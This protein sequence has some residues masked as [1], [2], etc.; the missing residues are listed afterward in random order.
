MNE[1]GNNN[2]DSF[3]N[4]CFEGT[5]F[6]DVL[7]EARTRVAIFGWVEPYPLLI[8][9]LVLLMILPSVF[10]H[11][12][13]LAKIARIYNATRLGIMSIFHQI[14]YG[15]SIAKSLNI[16]VLQATPCVHAFVF[17]GRIAL[18]QFPSAL[19]LSGALFAFTVMRFVGFT[20]LL[21]KLLITV[22]LLAVSLAEV[23]V[24]ESS[25]LQAICAVLLGY[26][27][28]YVTLR[29]PFRFVHIENVVL[30]LFA[31]AAWG[32]RVV[33]G[34]EP[35]K[36]FSELFFTW[37]VIAI[38][39]VILFRHHVTRGGFHTIGRPL[40]ISWVVSVAHA[41]ST[42][43]L[44]NEEGDF[45]R[46]CESDMVTSVAAFVGIFLGVLIRKVMTPVGFFAEAS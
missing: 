22:F 1:V 28:H 40:D 46:H 30:A 13:S 4:R 42:R 16:M 21:S 24:H 29:I 10:T 26:L 41:E 8:L 14:C 37:V 23:G 6:F 39:E 32:L 3:L 11:T 43:L 35:F 38:D 20:S 17:D 36:S 44:N 27:L 25:F 12:T 5:P 15:Y 45:R 34:W 2:G 18:L 9:S 19:I 33:H 31:L 7:F